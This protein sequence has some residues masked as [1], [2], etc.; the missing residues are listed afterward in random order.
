MNYSLR[1]GGK[2]L[3]PILL[4]AAAEL[5]GFS[6]SRVRQAACAIECIHTY[7]LIHDDLPAMDN[8]D[9]RRGKP[10]SHKRFGEGMAILAGDGLLTHA[11]ALLAENAKIV[12]IRNSSFCQV[13]TNVAE[14]AGL[15][16][17]VAGQAADINWSGSRKTGSRQQRGTAVSFIHAHKT[18]ALI[19]VS[20]T[21]G[22]LLAG[23]RPA[24]MRRLS[25]F[26]ERI[27]LAFQ[28]VDDVLELTRTREQLGKSCSDT[29]HNKLTYP[30]VYG[31]GKSRVVA[32]DLVAEA[33]GLLAP[34]G[35]GQWF[36]RA[37]AGYITARSN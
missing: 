22:G 4:V 1:A 36:L 20:L 24:M 6:A 14:A 13:V 25:A 31:L 26:G 2:R 11:F 21:T 33:Q 30:A 15:R 19:R 37:L 12:N 8:D 5:C 28:I 3:R 34:C 16:G 18:A 7:S 32:D 10:T 35:R 27:G 29:A 17:M 23:A 9:L